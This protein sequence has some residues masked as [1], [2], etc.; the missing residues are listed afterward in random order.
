MIQYLWISCD[1]PNIDLFWLCQVANDIQNDSEDDGPVEWVSYWKPN[2]TI[3][4]VADFTQYVSCNSL[5][6]RVHLIWNYFIYTFDALII[7]I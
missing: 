3:N 6:Y 4:L 5:N 1:D 2:I 7:S